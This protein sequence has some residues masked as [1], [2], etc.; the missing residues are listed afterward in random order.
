MPDTIERA[1]VPVNRA[2]SRI[3]RIGLRMYRVFVIE[4]VFTPASNGNGTTSARNAL[5]ILP[6]P[7]IKFLF[8]ERKTARRAEIFKINRL[9]YT[10][11]ILKGL[12]V[13]GTPRTA[14]STL[15]YGI[16]VR[17]QTKVELCTLVDDPRLKPFGWFVEVERT[18]KRINFSD[19]TILEQ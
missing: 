18:G 4:Q 5:E 8:N 17:G 12:T 11:E 3:E 7:R 15:A 16:Q 14:N 9:A 2:R 13:D 10:L 19:L 6:S 1:N